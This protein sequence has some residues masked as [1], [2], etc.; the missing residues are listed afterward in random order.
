MRGLLLLTEPVVHPE[1]WQEIPNQEVGPTVV[2]AKVDEG[3]DGNSKTN[4]TEKNQLGILGFVQRAVG[5]EVID[6]SEEAILLSLS[7]AL[8]LSLMVVVACNIAQKVV[9]P[10]DQLLP[11]KHDE[12]DDWGLLAQFGQFVG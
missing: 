12:G 6:T 7:T 11:E 10:T 5:V 1:V 4:V 3:R 9:G 8:N 2:V